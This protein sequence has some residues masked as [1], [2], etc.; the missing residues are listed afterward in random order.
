[1][2]YARRVTLPLTPGVD[3]SGVIA[4]VGPGVTARKVGDRVTVQ[5]RFGNESGADSISSLGVHAWGG[6]AEYVRAV[7]DR[8]AIVPDGLDF[9]T[10]KVASRHTPAAFTLLRDRAKLHT[11]E[12]ALV[13]GAA[14]RLGTAAL[15]APKY[16][17]AHAI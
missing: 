13:M 16:P 9:A 6:Y 15:R 11:V 12:R 2:K 5:L 8:T 10:A 1:G 7:A 4:K 3:P 14:R 17:G